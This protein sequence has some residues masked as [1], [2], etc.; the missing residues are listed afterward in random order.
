[1]SAAPP[2]G[3]GS[4]FCLWGLHESGTEWSSAADLVAGAEMRTVS[5]PQGRGHARLG[6]VRPRGHAVPTA[7]HTA[8]APL[9][10]ADLHESSGLKLMLGLQGGS[11]LVGD[12]DQVP[13][14]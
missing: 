10:R 13:H 5:T 14:L 6:P 9:L 1:M 4:A 2:Q 12:R 8:P 11:L 7:K 3:P